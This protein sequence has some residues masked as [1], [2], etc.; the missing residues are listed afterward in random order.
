[1]E[2]VGICAS[3]RRG[4]LNRLLLRALAAAAPPGCR[5]DAVEIG[6]VPLYNGD[7]EAQAFPA[8]VAAL[9][10]RVAACDGIVLCTPEYNGSLPGAGKNVFDWLSRP[11]Q[12]QARV[13]RGRPVALAGATPGRS[14]TAL[15]Q[16]QWGVVFRALG[17]PCYPGTLALSAAGALFG[18][19]GSLADAATQARVAAFM[20][21]FAGF[22][23]RFAR[24][25][26]LPS[27]RS[28]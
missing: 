19:D 17:M 10:D 24:G 16:V 28:G 22:A 25:G 15:A 13:L 3:L 23:A 1:M 5:V 8:A 26:P 18:A 9:K 14:G 11:P 27:H 4:S 21:G 6:D 20:A 12:D 2:F 7:V